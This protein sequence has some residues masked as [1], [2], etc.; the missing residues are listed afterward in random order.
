[1]EINKMLG[2]RESFQAPSALMKILKNKTARDELINQYRNEH[3]DLSVD[4]FREYFMESQSDR[5]GD[6][7]D[8]TPD[9]IGDIIAGIIGPRKRVLDIAGG[10]GGLTIHQWAGHHDG[11]FVVEEISSASLPFL[12]LNLL[13]RKINA[14]VIHGDSLERVAKDVY[15]ISDDDLSIEPHTP[16]LLA[17]FGLR[18]WTNEL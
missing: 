14:T 1:M 2:V 8:Y 18:G 6:K 17:K 7:Q 15:T 4:H 10:I 9:S 13:V 11:E 3:P 5:K 16:E 12:L